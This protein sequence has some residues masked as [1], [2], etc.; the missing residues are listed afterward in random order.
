MTRANEVT[1]QTRRKW[2]AKRARDIPQ[3]WAS[4]SIDQKLQGVGAYD[5]IRYL[6]DTISNNSYHLILRS[7]STGSAEAPPGMSN[8]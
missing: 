1:R 6:T 8:R 7:A 3:I 2:T 5:T 4:C